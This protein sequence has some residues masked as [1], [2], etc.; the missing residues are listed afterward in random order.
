LEEDLKSSEKRTPRPSNELTKNSLG[1]VRTKLKVI[2][3][4]RFNYY[5]L[6]V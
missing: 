3:E 6:V 2:K 1:P 5:K 4:V